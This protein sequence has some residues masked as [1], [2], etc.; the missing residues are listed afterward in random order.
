MELFDDSSSCV[1]DFLYSA[2]NGESEEVSD[3]NSE[4]ENEE[5][6]SS[7]HDFNLKE[8]YFFKERKISKALYSKSASG[9]QYAK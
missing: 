5:E 2:S 6:K 3:V 7:N 8:P 9:Q 1:E 4:M